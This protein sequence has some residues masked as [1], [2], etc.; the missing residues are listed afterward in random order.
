MQKNTGELYNAGVEHSTQVSYVDNAG[1]Q[2]STQVSYVD[3][4]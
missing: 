4:A 2:H 3:N 1:V